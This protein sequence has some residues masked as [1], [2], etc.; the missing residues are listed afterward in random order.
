[1]IA[2]SI[3]PIMFI[4]MPRALSFLPLLFGLIMSAWWVFGRKEKLNHSPN[5]LYCIAGVSLICVISV[6]WSIE[7]MGAYKQAV[8]ISAILLFSVPL[9]SLARSIKIEM[10]K[11]FLWLFPVG[12]TLA[13][14]LAI[15]EL[16]LDMPIYR[17]THVLDPNID[18]SSAVMNRG[19]ISTVLSFFIAIL[20]INNMEGSK[21]LKYGLL[22]IMSISVIAMLA[23]SQ[24]QS[25]QMA[26]I[27][28]LLVIVIMPHRYKF[29]YKMLALIIIAV[30]FLT[31][32]IVDIMFENLMDNAQEIPW[33]KDGYAGNRIEIWNFIMKYALNN[34][35]YG[36]G[37]EATRFVTNFEHDYIYHKGATILHPHNF[38]IQIWMDFGIIGIIA[39]S[40]LVAFTVGQIAKLNLNDRRIITALFI[41][42]LAVASTGYGM[43]QSWW[44]GEFMFVIALSALITKRT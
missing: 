37:M 30:M 41:A 3:M 4:H 38:S 35:L 28:G 9:F 29:L 15:F 23:L 20:F 26:F 16:A 40:A 44:I 33:L 27:V 22:A 42:M 36:Y 34:P 32:W 43:W 10:L 8:K 19:V 21:K 24:C 17:A 1:M 39:T 2:I 25:G 11:L 18:L 14:L 31:P 13:A 7:P 6:L 5:Y 12:V